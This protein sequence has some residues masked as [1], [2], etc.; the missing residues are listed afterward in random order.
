MFHSLVRGLVEM[1]IEENVFRPKG[2]QFKQVYRRVKVKIGSASAKLFLSYVS[3]LLLIAFVLRDS[4]R[5][6]ALETSH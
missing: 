6:I 2:V 1:F 5:E 4:F 3:R